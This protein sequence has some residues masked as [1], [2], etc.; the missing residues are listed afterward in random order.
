[1]TAYTSPTPTSPIE[2]N[3]EKRWSYVISESVKVPLTLVLGQFA[4]RLVAPEVVK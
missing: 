2:R 3:D 4:D 1:M